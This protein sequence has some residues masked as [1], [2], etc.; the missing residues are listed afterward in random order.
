MNRRAYSQDFDDCK[1]PRRRKKVPQKLLDDQPTFS[2]SQP[3]SNA[4]DF[5]KICRKYC[6][7]KSRSLACDKCE[8]WMHQRCL[9]LSQADFE[10]LQASNESWICPSCKTETE[11]VEHR[12]KR[13]TSSLSSNEEGEKVIEE[14]ESTSENSL[15][16]ITQTPVN[17]FKHSFSLTPASFNYTRRQ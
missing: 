5:C 13:S 11:W 8:C 15:P 17:H 10:H 3:Q 9:K 14:V 12:S 1:R 2:M 6:G 4:L 7:P 16:L